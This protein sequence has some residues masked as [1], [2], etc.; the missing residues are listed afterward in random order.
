M[1]GS[2][3]GRPDWATTLSPRT[4]KA[5]VSGFLGDWVQLI[6]GGVS[7]AAAFVSF[8]APGVTKFILLGSSL[9][10]V[11]LSAYRA[12]AGEFARREAAEKSVAAAH[13]AGERVLAAAVAAGEKAVA[14]TREAGERTLAAIRDETSRRQ[15]E[16]GPRIVAEVSPEGE[17]VLLNIGRSDAFE[18]TISSV[19]A[20]SSI[21]LHGQH[22]PRISAGD[23]FRM[24]VWTHVQPSPTERSSAPGLPEI[25]QTEE[26]HYRKTAVLR[27]AFNDLYGNSYL[28]TFRV[29]SDPL[30]G[31]TYTEHLEFRPL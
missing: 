30:V 3:P 8:A 10:C 18:V 13:T 22:V 6:C 31:N 14:A 23:R 20:D 11:L 5:F 21:E 12:F 27:S 7:V 25:L 16:N 4:L 15:I 28:S 1:D 29:V 26:G 9:L 24:M 2:K 19:G 17:L